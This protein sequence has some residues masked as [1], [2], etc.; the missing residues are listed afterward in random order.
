[1]HQICLPAGLN[2]HQTRLLSQIVVHKKIAKDSYLYRI[3]DPFTALYAVRVGHF[4]TYQENLAGNRQINGLQM[5]G[6]LL[7][8]DAISSARH[9]CDATALEDSEVCVIPYAQLETLFTEMP[10]LMRHFHRVM[11]KEIIGEQDVI[12]ILGN[13][14]AEQ[15]FAAFL[16]NLSTRYALRGYSPTRFQLRM[17]RE[18]IGNYLGL[19]I[20]SI[21]RM[22]AK[23][24]KN[25]LIEVRQR[26]VELLDLAALKKLAAGM[27]ISDTSPI[28]ICVTSAEAEANYLLPQPVQQPY[29]L[30]QG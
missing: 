17:T 13:M 3:G 12:M 21:S 29:S 23:L 10:I 16:V 6:D 19:T 26:D 30:I 25:G 5:S 24:R 8:M 15:R 20:E 18:D 9:Q 28:S 1:M 22:I 14:Y 2:E 7:G 4:K 11:S 27:D